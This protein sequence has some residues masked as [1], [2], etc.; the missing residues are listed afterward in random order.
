MPDRLPTLL[1]IRSA[2]LLACLLLC[3]GPGAASAESADLL[4]PET[5]LSQLLAAL[6]APASEHWVE[7]TPELVEQGRQFVQE[8]RATTSAGRRTRSLSPAFVCTD[9]HN[10]VREDP[11][12]AQSDPEARLDYAVEHDLPLLPAT[13]LWGLVNRSSWFNDDYVD[14]YGE[15]V[16]PAHDSLGD[17]IRLCAA[18]CSQGRLVADWEVEAML[19]YFWTLEITVG[20]LGLGEAE[21]A[22]VVLGLEG[23]AGRAEALD[24]LR[25]RFLAASPATAADPPADRSLGYGNAGDADRG[26]VI[27]ERS[28]MHCHDRGRPGKLVPLREGKNDEARLFRQRTKPDNRSYFQVIRYG[29]RARGVPMVYMP[30]YPAE[31]LSDAQVDDLSAWIR[32]R[33]GE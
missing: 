30:F 4:A 14:K 21:R 33:A 20:D 23:E 24:L 28:C 15:L 8:G 18:E 6:G 29:T 10:L 26:G 16:A 22:A 1:P 5:P 13:T 32:Q 2:P 12:L 17:A 9:C 11:D 25:G 27:Y 7:P 31:R 3:L 19:A